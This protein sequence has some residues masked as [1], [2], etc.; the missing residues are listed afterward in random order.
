ML[1]AID[2]MWQRHLNDMDALREGVRLRAQGQRDP[3]VEYKR[4]AYGLFENLMQDIQLDMI[5]RMFRSTTNLSAFE[6]FLAS[7]PM[8]GDALDIGAGGME[9][10]LLASLRGQLQQFHEREQ[11][12]ENEVASGTL[13]EGIPATKEKKVNLP[14]RKKRLVNIGHEK[15]ASPSSGNPAPTYDP[16]DDRFLSAWL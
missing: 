15:T 10:D 13:P 6:D 1:Q 11:A 7:L 5:S 3:L 9:G 2:K 8:D 12:V 4:E 16:E 14:N